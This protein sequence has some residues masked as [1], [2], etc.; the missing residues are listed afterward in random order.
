MAD[1]TFDVGALLDDRL[2]VRSVG[3]CAAWELLTRLG[4]GRTMVAR[5]CEEGRLRRD[6]V[7]LRRDDHVF[8][9]EKVELLFCAPAERVAGRGLPRGSAAS[10]LHFDRVL[11]AVNKPQGIL[12]HGDGTGAATLTDAAQAYVDARGL[13]CRPQ[14]IQRLDVQTS[15]VVL[16]SLTEEFQPALDHIVAE[17]RMTKRYLAVV[18]GRLRP[19]E[20]VIEKPI[21]RDRHNAKRMRVSGTGKQA[22][23]R[24]M[25]LV[26]RQGRS[27]VMVELDTGRRHQIRVHLASIG[28]AIVGDD[29]YGRPDD[30][31][32]CLHCLEERLVHPVTAEPLVVRAPWPERFGAWFEPSDAGL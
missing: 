13:A 29:L 2:V 6:G 18:R 5:V 26:T 19:G 27:L 16:F 23:T 7:P 15:G 14:A 21:G 31:G 4:L 9:G 8:S 22:R 12:V 25:P 20:V 11:L 17:H 32:L 3:P 30:V 10:V 1:A 28:H 24:V